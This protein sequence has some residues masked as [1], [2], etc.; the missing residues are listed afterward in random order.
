MCAYLRVGAYSRG[1][2][3][4]SFP[5][6]KWG[7]NLKGGA[8]SRIYGIQKVDLTQVK[9]Q[10]ITCPLFVGLTNK[11]APSNDQVYIKIKNLWTEKCQKNNFGQNIFGRHFFSNFRQIQQA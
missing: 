11:K 1:H 2:L 5:N 9:F 4:N 7:P 8:Y 3:F 6:I 10:P